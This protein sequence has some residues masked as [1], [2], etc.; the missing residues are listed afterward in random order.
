MKGIPYPPEKIED[1]LGFLAN[2]LSFALRQNIAR[3]CEVVGYKATPEGL[4]ILFLLSRQDD[5][6]QG[7]ISEFLAKDKAAV[8]RLLSFLEKEGLVQRS[9]D[10]EDRRVVRTH[11][12]AKG[13]TAVEEIAPAF[14]SFFTEVFEGVDTDEFNIARKVLRQIIANMKKKDHRGT[15]GNDLPK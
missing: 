10:S 2:Q 4:A 8:T 6:T 5:L 15:P 9:A 14:K 1:G 3:E 13:S 7:Q 12:T 11:I